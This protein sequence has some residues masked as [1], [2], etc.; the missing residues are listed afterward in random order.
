[1][2]TARGLERIAD[3]IHLRSQGRTIDETAFRLGLLPWRVSYL[4]RFVKVCLS[5]EE[6]LWVEEE[7]ERWGFGSV[8]LGSSSWT[9]STP[10]TRTST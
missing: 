9:S 2:K 1:M 5:S 7:S 4:T 3:M 10:A 8:R 6:L